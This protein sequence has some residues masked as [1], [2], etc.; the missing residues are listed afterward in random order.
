MWRLSIKCFFFFSPL[1]LIEI[2][3]DWRRPRVRNS[4]QVLREK[5]SLS[6]RSTL[7]HLRPRSRIIQS[8]CEAAA[9]QRRLWRC[10]LLL[11]LF[12]LLLLLLLRE[13]EDAAEAEK[14][15]P[16]FPSP[17][18]FLPMQRAPSN[19]FLLFYTPFL[20][21]APVISSSPAH[22]AERRR[23]EK[24]GMDPATFLQRSND[25]WGDSLELVQCTISPLFMININ[26]IQWAVTKNMKHFY[27]LII[28]SILW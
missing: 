7:Q 6:V 4:P 3:R 16:V 22:T 20:F 10:I 5:A 28:I 15:F 8:Q 24:C 18:H 9:E 17:S 11:L 1:R 27:Q 2:S 19:V 13:S 25:E 12:L 14:Y 26:S 21:V 23:G